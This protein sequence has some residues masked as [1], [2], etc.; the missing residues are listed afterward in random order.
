MKVKIREL[1]GKAL[2]WAVTQSLNYKV[3]YTPTTYILDY[4]TNET[5]ANVIISVF[6]IL[7]K[8]NSDGWIAA[9]EYMS[10]YEHIIEAAPTREIAAMQCFAISKLGETMDIPDDLLISKGIEC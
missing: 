1:T 3:K 2:D 4:S 7:V 8:Q 6:G 5:V 10:S 9:K